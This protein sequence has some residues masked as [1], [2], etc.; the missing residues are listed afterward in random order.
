MPTSKWAHLEKYLIEQGLVK[1]KA[2]LDRL[3]EEHSTQP[4]TEDD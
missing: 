3:L 2:D 1:N 4:I